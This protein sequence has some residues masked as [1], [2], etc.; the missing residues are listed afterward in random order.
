MAAS[1]ENRPDGVLKMKQ[2]FN[3]NW[4]K[5]KQ[6]RKQ[7]K[8]SANAPLH[9]KGKFVSANLD[10]ELRKKYHIRSLPVR[11]GDQVKIMR[12]GF[13]G[14]KGKVTKVII[15][16]SKI[17][18]DGIQKKK[19][20]GSKIDIKIQPSNVQIVELNLEDKKRIKTEKKNPSE[21]HKENREKK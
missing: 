18:I 4:K 6:P 20:D 5:S 12:G 3:K 7:R 14:K 16:L 8:Y 2:K 9:L 19:K 10:K 13:K 21:V 17:I 11:K 1:C 15:K